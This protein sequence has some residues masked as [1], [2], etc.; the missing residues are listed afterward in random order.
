MDQTTDLHCI[1]GFAIS[2]YFGFAR[3]TADLDVL[4]IAPLPVRTAIIAAAGKQ[5][6]LHRKHR[7]YVDQVGVASF[8]D[9]YES[10]LTRA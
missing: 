6:A 3:E 9:D 10:R 2:Q 8:P 4:T 1:G 7:V 5:S